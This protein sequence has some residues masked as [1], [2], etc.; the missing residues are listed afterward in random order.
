MEEDGL[1]AKEDYSGRDASAQKKKMEQTAS[2]RAAGEVGAPDVEKLPIGDVTQV[3]SLFADVEHEGKSW[4]CVVRKTMQKLGEPPIVGDRVRFRDT[5]V[6]D[7]KGRTEAV[8]EQILPRESVLT[9]TDSFNSL[10]SQPIVANASQMLIVT[11]LKE[12][13]IKW[14][15]IDRMMVAAQGGKLE[16]ILCMNKMDLVSGQEMEFAREAMGHYQK[17]GARTIE[18]SVVQNV[19]LEELKEILA[20]KTTVL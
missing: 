16:P 6:K 4:L 2:K 13:R 14:G 11:S 18:S 19:G 3:Y 7:E 15:I 9:R 20:G 5:G 1:D 8:I 10:V 17:L 12:P